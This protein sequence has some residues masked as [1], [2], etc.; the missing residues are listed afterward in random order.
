MEISE[1]QAEPLAAGTAS[2]GYR[3]EAGALLRLGAPIAATQLCV[4]GMGFLDT[5]M[6]GRY[7]AVD[8]AGVSL[9][10]VLLWPVFMLMSGITMAVMPM[11]S[12]LV[13][14]R[15]I[16]ESGPLIRHGLWIALFSSVVMVLI[17]R[18]AEP[19][20]LLMG[21][22]PGVTAVAAGY[23][24][25]ASWGMP[26]MM[27]YILL[28]QVCEG[29]GHTLPPM[30]I[31]GSAFALNAPLNYV[32]IYGAFGFPELGGVGCGWATA[33]VMWVELG[34]I[35]L[36]ARRPFF[37]ATNWMGGD[38]TLRWATVARIVKLGVPIGATIFLEMAV[39]SAI[40]V[41]IARLGVSEMAAHSVAGNINWATYVI[42]MSLGSAAAIRVG[43]H[44]GAGNQ[45]GAAQVVSTAFRI[46]LGYA[47]AVSI[48]LVGLRFVLVGV[49][50]TD[51][52]VAFI[53][54]NLIIFIAI[55]QIFDDA[56][57]TMAGALRGYKDTRVPMIIS[58]IGYWLIAL[59]LGALLAG[60]TL[61]LSG[62]GVYGYWAGMTFG[63]ALVAVAM[64]LRLRR[65]SGDAELIERLAQG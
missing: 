21:A 58:L 65:T 34:L 30:L 29:L 31:A 57:A 41:L 35:L 42:P 64:G 37:R 10:G 63:I 19:A 60:G 7:G 52:E 1:E 28:R 24:K 11:V 3:G 38:R 45:A 23:L 4:M 48:M 32:L 50:T 5:A 55:Y 13:G 51:A 36:V 46:S 15:R 43:F 14:A 6:A 17:L 44:V 25:A 61:G 59:P 22:D 27:T 49:Y 2:R 56:N 18:N 8:L 47:L 26:A 53:A 12:Q 9:G 40:S 16:G 54:A 39:Y 62:T 20:L 33:A